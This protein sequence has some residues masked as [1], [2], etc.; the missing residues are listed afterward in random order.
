MMVTDISNGKTSNYWGGG[1]R[2]FFT[3]GFGLQ[4]GVRDTNYVVEILEL[5]FCDEFWEI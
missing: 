4:D 3:G 2:E 5:L 1:Q